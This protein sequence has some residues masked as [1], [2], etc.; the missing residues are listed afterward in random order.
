MSICTCLCIHLCICLCICLCIATIIMQ[1]TAIAKCLRVKTCPYASHS[2]QYIP[3]LL[4]PL[5]PL[6]MI[7]SHHLLITQNVLLRL[8]YHHH[9]HPIAVSVLYISIFFTPKNSPQH[10]RINPLAFTYD[11][12]VLSTGTVLATFWTV[13]IHSPT[14]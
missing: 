8:P 5:L 4:L 9:L 12:R 11:F 3:S 1:Y 14:D 10:I 6:S 13:V 7:I 2:F